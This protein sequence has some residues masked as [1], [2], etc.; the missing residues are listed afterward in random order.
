MNTMKGFYTYNS[1]PQGA[2]S[3][4]SIFQQVM[5]KV[6]EGLENVSCYL[7]NVL[8]AGKSLEEYYDIMLLVL[9]RLANFN[10]KVNFDKCIFL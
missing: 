3:S 2:S 10:I 9:N 6:L 1:L 5:D 7:D 8:I 4:V